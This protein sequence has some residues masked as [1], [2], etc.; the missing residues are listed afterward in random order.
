MQIF[1]PLFEMRLV[2][3][4]SQSVHSRSG[5]LLE[6]EE[7]LPEQLEVDMMEEAVNFSFC[8][9]LATCRMRSSACDTLSRSCARYV[10]C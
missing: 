8:L 2:F 6:F 10:L 7:R 5:I 3:S 1:E 9:C 4:P